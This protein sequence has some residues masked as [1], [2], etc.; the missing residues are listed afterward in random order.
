MYDTIIIGRGPAGISCGVYLKRYNLNPLIIAKDN[1]ALD[2][3]SSID[4]YYGITSVSGPELAKQGIEQALS[5][6][7]PMVDDEVVSVEYYGHFVVKTPTREYEAKTLFLAMGKKKAQLKIKNANKFD[8]SG[9]SYCATC[10]GFFFR[11]KKIGVVGA[12]HYMENE[13]NV[14]KNFTG[15]ITI[16]TN[17]EKLNNSFENAKIVED[18]IEDLIGENRLKE[19]VAGGKSY[20]ID[21]LFVALGSQSGLSLAQHI[22]LQIDSKGYL[23]VDE[24][25]QTNMPGIFAGGDVIGGFLQVS[26]AASDGA[27]ASLFIKKYLDNLK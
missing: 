15:D 20:E 27:N 3:A 12:S 14:L 11:G 23:V 8:G 24:N 17:G 13:Y 21:G 10:D 5:L 18:K 22:G 1:G 4:N 25:F 16:F 7:I 6:G 19:V 2:E 9:V 26:K